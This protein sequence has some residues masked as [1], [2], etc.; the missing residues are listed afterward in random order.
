M[1]R[2]AGTTK[3]GFSLFELL[4]V[5][6]ITAVVAA[7]A[8]PRYGRASG[9]YRA[10]LAARRV[11]ADLRLAQSCAKAASCSRTVSFSTA[12]GRYQLL[13]I[14]APDGAQG[15]YTVVL[16]AEPYL[17]DL[18]NVNFDGSLQVI[19]NGWGLPNKGGTV[20]LSAGGEQRTVVVDG[21]TGRISVQ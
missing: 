14:P 5:L 20:T 10:D 15:D 8:A 7:V 17:A 16:S 19:F 4:L 11:M 1:N 3:G 2:G 9:R 21:V 6:A 13:S 18:T 12:T